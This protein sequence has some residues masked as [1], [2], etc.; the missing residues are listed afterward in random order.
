MNNGSLTTLIMVITTV[1]LNLKA[2]PQMI[3]KKIK[4]NMVVMYFA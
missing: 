4:I 3:M 1:P 2:A